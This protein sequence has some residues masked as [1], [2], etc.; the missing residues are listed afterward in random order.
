[1]IIN[2]LPNRKIDQYRA[3]VGNEGIEKIMMISEELKNISITNINSTA[4]GGVA[5][6]LYSLVPLMNS[7]G[8]KTI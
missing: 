2:N 4:F 7:I 5:E 1:M 3:I 6:I 8:I